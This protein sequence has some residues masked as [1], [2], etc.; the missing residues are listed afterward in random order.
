[1]KSPRPPCWLHIS[2]ALLSLCW[3]TSNS[4][5]RQEQMLSGLPPLQTSKPNEC[6]VPSFTGLPLQTNIHGSFKTYPTPMKPCAFH[7]LSA[8]PMLSTPAVPMPELTCQSYK[9]SGAW[10]PPL[11]LRLSWFQASF[12]FLKGQVLVCI[13]S[14]SPKVWHKVGFNHTSCIC[15]VNETSSTHAHS[16]TQ[17][18]LLSQFAVEDIEAQGHLPK[19]PG[20]KL[21]FIVRMPNPMLCPH[22]GRKNGPSPMPSACG[23]ASPYEGKF[24]F[25]LSQCQV[26]G[27]LLGCS[28]TL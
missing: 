9:D 8:L 7:S 17:M 1:M 6:P 26:G 12:E 11:R 28:S 4:V 16:V 27:G 15:W 10:V 23:R 14:T 22:L 13:L 19:I 21:A 5:P 18:L 20:S 25:C 3:H 2:T 24:P